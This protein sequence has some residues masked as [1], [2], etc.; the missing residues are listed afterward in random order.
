MELAVV[1]LNIFKRALVPDQFKKPCAPLCRYNIIII[2]CPILD[3]V[4]NTI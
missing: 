4:H 1:I 3:I 2:S